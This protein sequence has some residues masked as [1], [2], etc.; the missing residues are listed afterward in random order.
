[1]Y[2]VIRDGF[3]PHAD[4]VRIALKQQSKIEAYNVFR[5]LYAP[6]FFGLMLIVKAEH[7]YH[8]LQVAMDQQ[9]QQTIQ[10]LRLQRENIEKSVPII[11]QEE[12]Q[13]AY[14]SSVADFIQKWGEAPTPEERALLKA[15]IEKALNMP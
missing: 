8:D 4:E 3:N 11:R 10:Q 13:K 5:K 14:E 7:A 15:K 12:F 1:M 2:K 9:V 6:I